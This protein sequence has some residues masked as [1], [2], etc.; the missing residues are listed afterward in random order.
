MDREVT[1]AEIKKEIPARSGRSMR[2]Y[3]LT[4]SSF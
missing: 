1:E 2:G 3:I 4:Y